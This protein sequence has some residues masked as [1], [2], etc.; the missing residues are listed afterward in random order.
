MSI[1]TTYTQQHIPTNTLY[2][3]AKKKIC[4]NTNDN[5]RWYITSSHLSFTFRWLTKQS[6]LQWILRCSTSHIFSLHFDGMCLLSF[7][8]GVLRESESRTTYISA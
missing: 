7:L 4:N 5:D 1:Y 2:V 6:I 8:Y 3:R